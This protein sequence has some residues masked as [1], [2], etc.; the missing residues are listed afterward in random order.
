MREERAPLLN[1]STF[2]NLGGNSAAR[3]RTMATNILR[4][5]TCPENVV[6]DFFILYNLSTYFFFYSRIMVV[7]GNK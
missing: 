3:M 2:W 4:K 1:P 5:M 6:K 7:G